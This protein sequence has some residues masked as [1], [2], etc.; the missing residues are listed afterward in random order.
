MKRLFFGLSLVSVLGLASCIQD[1]PLNSEC[2]IEQAIVVTDDPEA[3][4]LNASEAIKDVPSADTT[5]VFYLREEFLDENYEGWERL[6]NVA[7]NFRLTP[8]ATITP[9]SG[10]THDFTQGGVHYEITS[11][12]GVWHRSYH[13]MFVP[14]QP[15][16]TDY[17]FENFRWEQYNRY[18]E[19]FEYSEQGSV[20]DMWATGNPGFAISRSSATPEEYPT[21]PWDNESISG[22][23]VKLETRDTGPFGIM[24]NMRIAA[25]NL[26]IGTFDVANALQDAMAATQFGLPFNPK[27]LRFEGY[28]KF[29]PGKDFQNRAGVIQEGR[30]DDPD[31]YAV[32]YENTDENGQT[33]TLQGDNVLTHP[34]IVALARV[35]D[36]VHDF[37]NWTHFDIPFEYYQEIEEERLKTYG[38]SLAVVFTSS[39]EGASFCGAVG[40]TLLVDEVKV[41]CEEDENE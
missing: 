37:D 12:D 5:I 8:E 40:S 30:I 36:R 33:F 32:L 19:W 25:G 14:I 7:I 18:N 4:L 16:E 27:P 3:W 23:S 1:E 41:I 29:K 17:S 31:L 15:L 20:I 35:T 24:M 34:N 10:S 2:D 11:E 38:Y 21:I 39:I 22:H 6:K 28:Y 9:A 26:F 13:V